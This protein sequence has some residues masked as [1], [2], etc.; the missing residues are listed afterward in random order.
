VTGASSSAP[1]DDRDAVIIG[2][3]IAA[4]H[5]GRA[6][7]VVQL[8]YANGGVGRVTLDT[9]AGLRLL[10]NCGV[11]DTAHLIGHSWRRILEERPILENERCST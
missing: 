9:D 6:E 8:R 10:R 2:A 3:E 1:T 4:G 11:N 5:D 7:L